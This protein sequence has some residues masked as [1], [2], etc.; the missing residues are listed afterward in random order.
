LKLGQLARGAS[1]TQPEVRLSSLDD[2]PA[3]T[4]SQLQRRLLA[5]A[6]DM[7]GRLL[8]PL[9]PLRHSERAPL[10]AVAYQLE[11]QLGSAL[12]SDLSSSLNALSEEDRA[13]LNRTVVEPGLLAV[14]IPALLE[15][16]ALARRVTLLR[17]FEPTSKLPPVG[18]AT[19]DQQ[20]LSAS[21]W[22]T[23]GYVVLG[24]RAFRLDLAERVAG[25]LKRDKPE[26]EALACLALPKRE[27]AEVAA[28][29]RRALTTA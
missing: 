23:L 8:A 16:L 5:F 14:Y 9:D 11:H 28:G 25:L 12:R 17:A 19:F 21:A 27:W 1:L 3:G 7:V 13:A 18:R 15:P 20:H 10:R 24:R 22:M 2:V 29:F 4:R 26:R 6:R